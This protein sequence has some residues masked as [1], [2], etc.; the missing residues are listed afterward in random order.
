MTLSNSKS[1]R[2][3]FCG[4]YAALPIHKRVKAWGDLKREHQKTYVEWKTFRSFA[5]ASGLDIDPRSIETCN[6][7][8]SL[9]AAAACA[10][11]PFRWETYFE[12][13]EVTSGRPRKNRQYSLEKTSTRLRRRAVSAATDTLHFLKKC[14]NRYTTKGHP[15]HSSCIS[16]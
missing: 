9:A 10:V 5:G 11:S 1:E 6:P 12:L 4:W 2:A 14:R 7:N 3:A 15:P 8:A 16:L 13:G